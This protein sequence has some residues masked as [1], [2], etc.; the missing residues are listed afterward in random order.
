MAGQNFGAFVR[1]A[2]GEATESLLEEPMLA[3]ALGMVVSDRVC[4]GRKDLAT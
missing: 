1:A 2:A 4:R 3:G